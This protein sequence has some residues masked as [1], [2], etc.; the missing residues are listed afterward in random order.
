MTEIHTSKPARSDFEFRTDSIKQLLYIYRDRRF[1][2][3]HFERLTNNK[4]TQ[5]VI[6]V[7]IH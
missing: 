6:S 1:T 3:Q 5:T 7:K 4:K 2:Q